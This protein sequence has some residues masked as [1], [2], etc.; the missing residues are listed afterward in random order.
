LTKAQGGKGRETKRIQA[1]AK[2]RKATY[3]GKFFLCKKIASGLAICIKW[4]LAKRIKEVREVEAEAVARVPGKMESSR[5]RI[6]AR[7][8]VKGEGI[9]GVMDDERRVAFTIE[10]TNE[11]IVSPGT[12]PQNEE[13][14]QKSAKCATPVAIPSKDLHCGKVSK[15]WER[16]KKRVRNKGTGKGEG[17]RKREKGKGTGEENTNQIALLELINFI[18]QNT[19]RPQQIFF[20]PVQKRQLRA[21][22][23]VLALRNMDD[24]LKIWVDD[25]VT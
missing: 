14:M 16:A 12:K 13:G 1:K 15:D 20:K 8:N 18:L 21:R 22:L 25:T 3:W 7:L 17:K 23:R 9:T 2:I 10:I 4:K 6:L 24:H 5:E 11:S 19:R